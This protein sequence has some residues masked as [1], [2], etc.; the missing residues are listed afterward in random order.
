MTQQQSSCSE[1]MSMART[2]FSEAFDVYERAGACFISTPLM[3]HDNDQVVLRLERLGDG[4]ILITDGGETIDYLRLSGFTVR[5]NSAFRAFLRTVDESFKVQFADEQFFVEATEDEFASAF[6]AV[7]RVAQHVSYMVYRRR[8]RTVT[9]FEERVEVDL[10]QIGA[11]YD[12]DIEIQGLT[13][14]ARFRFLLDSGANAIV[15]PLTA[16]SRGAADS[17]AERLIFHVMDVKRRSDTY[18]FFPVLDDVGRSGEVWAGD[19]IA[20]LREYTDG[21][22]RWSSDHKSELAQIAGAIALEES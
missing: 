20:S 18:H 11:S 14:L 13:K 3:R 5:G 19:T 15:Q 2:A 4:N 12:R 6:D 16:T 7:A 22:I 10:I 17:K 21:V 8:T 9:T 1:L